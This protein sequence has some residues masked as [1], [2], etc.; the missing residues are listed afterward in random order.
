MFVLGWLLKKNNFNLY[1]DLLMLTCA[2][3][4][5]LDRQKTKAFPIINHKL[6]NIFFK[7]QWELLKI[8]YLSY[9]ESFT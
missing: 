8:V 1:P 4:D 7:I 3:M 2:Y 9:G 6:H 5:F